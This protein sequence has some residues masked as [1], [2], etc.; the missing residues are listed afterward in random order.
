MKRRYHITP[1]GRPEP[2]AKEIERLKDPKRLLH[3]YHRA[4][5]RPKLPIY[6]DPKAFLALLL[7]VLLAWFLSEVV[8]APL[9]P[10]PAR[11]QL[12]TDGTDTTDR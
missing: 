1:E 3:N 4:V 9:E 12:P 2:T 10:G 11:E 8:D 6:R 7:I 5:Q